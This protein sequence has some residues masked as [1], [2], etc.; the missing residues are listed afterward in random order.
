MTTWQP[1]AAR[2]RTSV[3]IPAHGAPFDRDLELAVIDGHDVTAIDYPCRR[4]SD[5]WKSAREREPLGIDPTHW[6][7]W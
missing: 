1:G 3:W 5:G 4:E 6:R 7:Y 2:Q